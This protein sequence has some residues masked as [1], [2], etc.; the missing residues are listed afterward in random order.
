VLRLLLL[1]D[2]AVQVNGRQVGD[3]VWR[4][5]KARTL[6]KLLALA[7]DHV[8]HR[9][10]LIEAMWPDAASGLNNLDEMGT[11][12]ARGTASLTEPGRRAPRCA[13]G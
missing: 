4:R 12:V 9:D 1:G 6:V 2:F 13:A 8:L 5:R 10:Q 7:P 3:A 11:R